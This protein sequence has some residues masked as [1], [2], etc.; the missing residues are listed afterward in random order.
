[1]SPMIGRRYCLIREDDAPARIDNR[2]DLPAERS[3]SIRVM[4]RVVVETGLLAALFAGT[5]AASALAQSTAD[6]GSKSLE[7]LM[8]IKVTSASRKEEKLF[9]T[10]AAIYV[11]TQE[12]IRRSGMT[13]LPDLLRMVPGVDVGRVDGVGWAV[14]VRGFNRRFTS[15]LLVLIDGRSVYSPDTSGVYWEALD[16]PLETIDR[17]EVI[18]GP[19]GTLWGANAVNGVINIITKR[20]RDSQGGL[21]TVVGGSE[22][23]IAGV[24]YGGTIGSKA[25]YSVN[26]K[27]QN[28]SGLV[29]SSGHDTND[30]EN[31][32]RG[33][34]RV[35]WQ[36]TE[37][38]SVT[39][40]GDIYDKGDKERLT[41]VSSLLDPLAPPKNMLARFSGGDVLGRWDHTFSSRS[42]TSLQIYYDRFLTSAGEGLATQENTFDIDFQHHFIVGSR[43]DIVWGLGYRLIGEAS[44]DVPNGPIHYVPP[45]NSRQVFSA[46][47]QDEFSL[48]K[49]RLRLT[50]GAKLEHDVYAGFNLQPNVRLLWTPTSHQTLWAAV[51]RAVR[52][53]SRGEEDLIENFAAFP[54]PEGIPVVLTVFNNPS[55]KSEDL[56][57]YELGYRVQPAGNLSIDIASFYNV[58]HR[59]QTDAFGPIFFQLDPIPHLVQPMTFGNQMSGNTYGVETS[60]TLKISPFWKITGSYSFLRMILRNFS[61]N[62]LG[63]NSD[64]NPQHQFQVRSYIDLPKRLE[65]DAAAYY[66]SALPGQGVRAYARIDARLG[67]H[68]S[69]NV[70]LSFGAQN[71]GQP[72]HLESMADDASAVPTLV[73]RT[74]Y[75]KL[76]WRF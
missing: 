67:W 72:R 22:D 49:D 34:M 73:K 38:D 12:D 41:W 48:I 56:R 14:G 30:T 35:D 75:G 15:K 11:I 6:L 66:V 70:E 10:A 19:G 24:Q 13:R 69:E 60:A 65:F 57:S 45:S 3:R 47:F 33:R 8:D 21:V 40:Q 25:Y 32:V 54:T 9:Q 63:D 52:T 18:R 28:G 58:Y 36:P 20:A 51:S 7:E 74:V 61:G 5:L 68:A 4:A 76:S 62:L 17:I 59:L 31:S 29:D 44:Q 43:Q 39:V 71:L 42:D 2:M 1:M 23:R 26:G 53:P 16:I 55:Y 37:R 50:A 64:D 46:F 27:Y